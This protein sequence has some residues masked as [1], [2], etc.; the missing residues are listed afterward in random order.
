MIALEA[1]ALADIRNRFAMEQRDGVWFIT[2]RTH[3]DA[4]ACD[5]KAQANARLLFARSYARLHGDINLLRFPNKLS[6]PFVKR[7]AAN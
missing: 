3:G 1:T 5:S 4:L 7:A 2:D 6:E